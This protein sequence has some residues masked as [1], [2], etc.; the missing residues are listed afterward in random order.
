LHSY[1]KVVGLSL[2]K[3]AQ[4]CTDIPASQNVTL[5]P[6]Y[7]LIKCKQTG[8]VSDTTQALAF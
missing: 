2:R 6:K 7:E 5:I 8:T 1:K 3:N 4:T